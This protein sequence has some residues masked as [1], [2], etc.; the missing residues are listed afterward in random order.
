MTTQEI[1]ASLSQLE[2]ELESIAS[3]RLLAENTITAYK[4]VQSDIK[5]FFSEF[6]K[7]MVCLNRISKAFEAEKSTL[8]SD[9]KSTV[10]ILKGQMNTLNKT[11]AEQC[12]T[13]VLSFVN[14]S[15]EVSEEFKNKT[16]TLIADY[17]LNNDTFKA[18]ITEL[19]VVQRKISKVVESVAIIKSDIDTLQ[20]QL[21]NSQKQQEA[22]LRSIV[23]ELELKVDGLLNTLKQN[24]DGVSNKLNMIQARQETLA[25]DV[26][27]IKTGI[28]GLGSLIDDK[29]KETKGSFKEIL[30]VNKSDDTMII[31]NIIFS[32]IILLMVLFK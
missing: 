24:V 26:E 3:A 23:A 13:I 4:E 11:F 17:E 9:V 32:I 28:S 21:V 20:A 7:V 10:D 19:S 18:R 14:S 29:S 6:K 8:T 16:N 31:V 22:T 27:Y 1:L 2:K 15:N 25:S 12:N 30:N 5:I